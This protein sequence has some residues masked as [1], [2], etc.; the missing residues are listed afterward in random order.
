MPAC[1]ATSGHEPAAS[2]A[3]WSFFLS[4][5]QPSRRLDILAPRQFLDDICRLVEKEAGE[6][7][8]VLVALLVACRVTQTRDQLALVLDAT[9]ELV[10]RR[11]LEVRSSVALA[12]KALAAL[13]QRREVQRLGRVRPTHSLP[14]SLVALRR[15]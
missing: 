7:S 15:R 3:S 12:S 2:P 5:H 10:V 4:H 8:P 11:L 6:R 9:H 13:A 1:R 14:L